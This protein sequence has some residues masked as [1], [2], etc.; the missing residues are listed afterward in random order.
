MAGCLVA[1]SCLAFAQNEGTFHFDIPRQSVQK[2]LLDL[3]QQAQLPLLL[4]MNAFSDLQANALDGEYS[5]PEALARLLEGTRVKARLDQSGQLIVE[6]IADS[7]VNNNLTGEARMS[8]NKTRKNLLAAAIAGLFSGAAEHALAQEAASAQGLE[9]ITVTGSRIR[10][11]SGFET[12]TP[13]TSITP[14]EL[15][16]FEP[17]NTVSQ[18]LNALPQFFNNRTSQQSADGSRFSPAANTYTFLNLRSLGGNRT[19]VLL[20]GHRLQPSDKAGTVNPDLLPNA[21]MRSVDVVTGGASAAYGADAVGGVVNFILDREF[22]GLKLEASTGQHEGGVGQ[23]WQVGVAAGL[24]FMAGRLHVV[25]SFDNLQID[26]I[27]G[28][29]SSISSFR[30]WGWVRNPDW[31]PTAPLGV[32]QRL[33]FPDV[34]STLS[35]PTGLITAPGTPLNRMQFSLDGSGIVPFVN[36]SVTSLP[37]QQGGTNSTTGGPEAALAYDTFDNSPSASA[38]VVRS[39]FLGVKYE[40]SER[41]SFTLDGRAGRTESN[42][43]SVRGGFE[44]ESPWN[45]LI[46]PDNAF[47]PAQVRDLMLANNIR[48]LNVSK[49][50]SWVDRPEVG[51]NTITENVLTQWQVSTGFEYKLPGVE[52]TLEGHYQTGESKRN[53]E[54][55]NVIR[56]DRLYLAMDAVRDPGSGKIVCRV[57]LYNPTVEQLRAAVAG[58][59]SGIPLDPTKPPGV[60]GNTKPLESPIGLDNTIAACVPLNPLGSGNM[61]REA[62]DYVTSYKG[63]DGIV[64]QNFAELLLS[65]ELYPLPA[66]MLSFAAGLTWREQSFYDFPVTNS[67]IG[68]DG[69]IVTTADLGPPINAPELGIRGIPAGIETGSPNLHLFS[70]VPNI[71]GDTSVTE[72]FGELQVPVWEWRGG[73]RIDTNLAFRRSNYVRSGV[74]DSWKIGIESRLHQDWRLR[75]TRSRDVREPTFQE[76]F[77]AQGGGSAVNDP[78]FNNASIQ[79]NTLSGGDPNLAP[80][81][82]DTSTAGLIWQPSFMTALEGLQVALDWYD[83]KIADRVDTLTAQRILDE[84]YRNSLFCDRITRDSATQQLVNVRQSYMNLSQAAVS[85]TDLEISWRHAVSFFGGAAENIGLR[86]LGAYLDESSTTPFGGTP[87]NI[88]GQ[89]GTPRYTHVLTAN[90]GIGAYSFQLQNRFVDSTLLNVDWVEGRDV[91]INSVASMSWWNASVGYRGETRGGAAWSVNL[92]IQNL[93]NDEPPVVPNFSTRGGSQS[94]PASYDVFGRRYNLSLNYSF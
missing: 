23:Q 93:L 3:A 90:Y 25:G 55:I 24:S 10:N 32:P 53:P 44:L 4:P 40:F 88:A 94:F 30:R 61:S 62:L 65:G 74:S 58:R 86:W 37:G 59:S 45:M 70:T 76:L 1:V 33:T 36:G 66:G 71:A 26:Q 17:G 6:K 84:C 80:E 13:V 21:L 14:S 42:N 64:T 72:W 41:L 78:F 39:S 83:I 51:S 16:S 54:G 82:G 11:T 34:V 9:E 52:W 77:D 50:G 69:K 29:R 89:V 27:R 49:L 48:E 43:H 81:I 68:V 91:D 38:V 60:P 18:Q 35:S 8:E 5:V 2:A 15:K 28:D 75:L 47:L 19:L 20:D 12:P 7:G 79:T 67:G 85:G 56:E 22:E 57:Q 87:R 63:A 31:T 73:Q 46:A 92:N